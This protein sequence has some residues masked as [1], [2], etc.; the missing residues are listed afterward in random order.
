MAFGPM[1]KQQLMLG[2]SGRAKVLAIWKLGSKKKDR[3]G[4]GSNMP[5]K[6][7]N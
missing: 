4:S 5:S 7:F 6:E 1:V 3:R 2:A